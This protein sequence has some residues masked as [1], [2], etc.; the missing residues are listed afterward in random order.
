MAYLFTFLV[1]IN[2]LYLGFELLRQNQPATMQPVT[3]SLQRK[4]FPVT[5]ELVAEKPV[6]TQLQNAVN[7]ATDKLNN[8]GH[9]SHTDKPAS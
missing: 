9:M 8:L 1:A 3:N 7:S 4:N 5:L 6:L 2:A